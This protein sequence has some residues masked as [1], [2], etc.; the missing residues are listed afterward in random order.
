[1]RRV[2]T[3]TANPEIKRLVALRRR[4]ERDASG[5]FVV[6]GVREL[7]RA[8]ESGIDLVTLYHCPSLGDGGDLLPRAEAAGI[9]VVEVGEQAFRKASF[10]Q[11]PDGL[12]AVASRFSTDLV[13]LELP[14]AALALVVEAVEKPGNLGTML[15]SADGAGAA[16][17]VA[18]G[19]TDPFN[20]NVVRASQGALFTV[21][22]G[23]ASSREVVAW[24]A[25]NELAVVAADPGGDHMIWD[26]DYTGGTAFVVGSEHAGLSALWRESARTVRIP[27]TG[28]AD[29]LNA[30]TTAGILLFEA[31]RQRRHQ[32]GNGSGSRG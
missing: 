31:V 20:P 7:S 10:R 22:L 24:L 3:S 2:I 25:A 4:R 14:P 27:M 6:E 23:M 8:I 30:A 11:G 16:V 18:D 9:T 26:L 13:G 32:A 12:L 5:A 29:S 19:A 17:V 28:A 15:R 21:R 1:M